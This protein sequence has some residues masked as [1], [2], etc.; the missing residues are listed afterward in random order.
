M[1]INI[2]G[3]NLTRDLLDGKLPTEINYSSFTFSAGEHQVRIL[4][5]DNLDSLSEFSIIFVTANIDGRGEEWV[6]LLLILDAIKRLKNSLNKPWGLELFIPYLPYSRQDRVCAEGEAFSLSVFA[7]SLRPYL[8]RGDC[9]TTWDIHSP[10]ANHIFGEFT[11][12]ENEQVD[13]LLS[14]FESIPSG[15]EWN[16][17]T[18]IIA[19]DKGAVP[20]AEVAARFIG[21]PEVKYATKVRN[22]ENGEILRTEVPDDVNYRG[23]NLLIVDDICDGGRT[24]IELAK[25]LRTYEPSR[26][27][28]YIT[29]G[30][31]SKGFEVFDG[32]IDSIYVA[33][34][35]MKLDYRNNGDDSGQKWFVSSVDNVGCYKRFP[36][37]VTYLRNI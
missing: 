19:P 23:K 13:S 3:T 7:N 26:I 17:A 12:F 27:D 6:K 16:P 33:N 35:L 25:V 32:L 11:N 9:L 29:H 14:M 4:D 2:A 31:F 34:L 1:T 5:G 24:F 10:V 8:G 30:I 22:P 20:R 21:S 15:M 36:S 37:N 18:V 28:L